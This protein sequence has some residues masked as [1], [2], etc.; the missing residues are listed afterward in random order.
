MAENISTTYAFTHIVCLRT[1][2]LAQVFIKVGSSCMSINMGSERNSN[3]QRKTKIWRTQILYVLHGARHEWER[4]CSMLL[5]LPINWSYRFQI[6]CSPKCISGDIAHCRNIHSFRLL[7]YDTKNALL[8]LKRTHTRTNTLTHNW[9]PLFAW[10][11]DNRHITA[12]R[13][14][15]QSGDQTINCFT[16]AARINVFYTLYTHTI[17]STW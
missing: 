11:A 1:K 6:L 4:I 5:H 15:V 16:I 8:Q 17:R 7:R 12:Q 9:Q 14:P 2:L 3:N 13:Q 10:H